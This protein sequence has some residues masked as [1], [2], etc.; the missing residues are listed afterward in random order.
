VIVPHRTAAPVLVGGSGVRCIV[1]LV[2]SWGV[3]NFE[4][5]AAAE[6]FLLVEEAPDPGVVMASTI[7]E[8][9]ARSHSRQSG[10]VVTLP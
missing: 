6:W 5:D 2:V 9:L 3:A 1:G 10:S 4:N 8:V 7:D